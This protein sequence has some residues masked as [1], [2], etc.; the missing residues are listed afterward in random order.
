MIT[1]LKFSRPQLAQVNWKAVGFFY[2]LACGLSYGL[3]FLPNPTKDILPLHT[4]FTYG[5]GPIGAALITR[6]VF[7]D[8]PR[9]IT[10]G[11]IKS[12]RTALF[13]GTP[14]L[15]G[16]A[17][18]VT[19]KAGQNEHIYGGLVAFS[20]ILYGF[21]EEAGWRGFLQDALRP[22]PT[23]WRVLIIGTMWLG[24]HFT[25]LP[26]L[27]GVAGPQTPIWGVYAGLL[28]A[29][30]GF[31]DAAE[32]TKSVMVVACLHEA[33]NLTGSPVALGLTL[34]IWTL[35]LVYWN[36]SFAEKTNLVESVGCKAD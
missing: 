34:L 11:G 24:W 10:L 1:A 31:G 23:F 22:L 18:G 9:T 12:F 3:H 20:G 16:L 21:V 35:L 7:R 25:F 17:F 2:V 4:V 15:L 13:V 36:R 5:L 14:L 19:N 32:R 26:D 8:V 28:L 27:S 29:S 6:F 33:F 30:W